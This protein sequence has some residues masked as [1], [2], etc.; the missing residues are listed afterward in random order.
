LL[1]PFGLDASDPG[2]WTRGLDV[3]AGF[4]DELEAIS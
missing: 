4:I 1:E 3:I 2:F